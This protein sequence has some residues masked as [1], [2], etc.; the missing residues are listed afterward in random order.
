MDKHTAQSRKIPLYDKDG[1]TVI[2]SFKINATD[3]TE[4]KAE[5]IK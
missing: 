5:D 3:V 1:K 2:G 4:L